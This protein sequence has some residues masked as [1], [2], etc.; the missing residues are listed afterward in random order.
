L[1]N[2]ELRNTANK[3]FEVLENRMNS[4]KCLSEVFLEE[5]TKINM[6]I[7]E[8]TT[9]FSAIRVNKETRFTAGNSIITRD[10]LF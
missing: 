5:S 7:Q 8:L 9:N 10:V 1:N 2:I 3:L 6:H 4:S